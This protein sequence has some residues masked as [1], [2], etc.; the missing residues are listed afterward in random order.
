MVYLWNSFWCCLFIHQWIYLPLSNVLD[1]LMLVGQG[2]ISCS[3]L[4]MK[5]STP[6]RPLSLQLLSA[7]TRPFPFRK[8]LSIRRYLYSC[9]RHAEILSRLRPALSS[10]M[11]IVLSIEHMV[12]CFYSTIWVTDYLAHR[13]PHWPRPHLVKCSLPLMFLGR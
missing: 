10:D 12:W 13:A 3:G 5:S 9:S 6:E 8:F 7:S 1:R 11:S 2:A 4:P